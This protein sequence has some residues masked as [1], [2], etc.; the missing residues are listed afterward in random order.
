LQEKESNA[1]VVPKWRGVVNRKPCGNV[2]DNRDLEAALCQ[3]GVVVLETPSAVG[4]VTENAL[5]SCQ[6][7]QIRG[8]Y[9]AVPVSLKVSVGFPYTSLINS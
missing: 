4:V 9:F 2:V 3:W 1:E 6:V 5:L 8:Q 7:K